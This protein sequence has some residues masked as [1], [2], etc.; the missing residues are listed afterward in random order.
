MA[1]D[2]IP[3][4]A[5]TLADALDTVLDALEAH[6]KKIAEIDEQW[7]DALRKSREFEK[8]KHD[9]KVFDTEL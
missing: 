6:P 1:Q 9:S 4:G 2:A 3:Y 8:T 5:I 7:S